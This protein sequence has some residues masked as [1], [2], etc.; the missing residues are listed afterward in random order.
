MH[1]YWFM[2]TYA[3]VIFFSGNTIGYSDCNNNYYYHFYDDFNNNDVA[4]HD[5][6]V[7]G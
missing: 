2:S 3:I 4:N 1:N 5:Y 7:V 6:F